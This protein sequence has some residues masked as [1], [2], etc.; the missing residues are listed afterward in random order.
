MVWLKFPILVN[1]SLIL[2][3]IPPCNLR[4]SLFPLSYIFYLLLFDITGIIISFQEA[5]YVEKYNVELELLT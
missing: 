5:T 4:F 1:L 3:I 2:I